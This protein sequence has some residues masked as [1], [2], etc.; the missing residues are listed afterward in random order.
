MTTKPALFRGVT[1]LG[2]PRANVTTRRGSNSIDLRI[3]A[4]T[5]AAEALLEAAAALEA[6]HE[7]TIRVN[8]GGVAPGRIIVTTK[9]EQA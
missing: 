6:G 8:D 5:S 3:P 1:T 9:K 2:S 7:V 4:G